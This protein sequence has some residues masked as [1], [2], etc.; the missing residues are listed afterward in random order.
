MLKLLL[1]FDTGSP[2]FDACFNNGLFIKSVLELT[3]SITPL[4]GLDGL[5][6][7]ASIFSPLSLLLNLFGFRFS[8]TFCHFCWYSCKYKLII[9]TDRTTLSCFSISSFFIFNAQRSILSKSSMYLVILENSFSTPF[10]VN[11]FGIR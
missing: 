8:N 9:P 10:K 3:T 5:D 1:I 11:V 4:T 7:T 6:N 2:K